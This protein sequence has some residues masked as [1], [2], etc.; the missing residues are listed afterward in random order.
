RDTPSPGDALGGA[1]AAGTLD[2]PRPG[3]GVTGDGSCGRACRI[4]ARR[5]RGDRR[6]LRRA[7]G[8]DRPR[9]PPA[10]AHARRTGD[11]RH[12]APAPGGGDRTVRDGALE[13]GDA[14]SAETADRA[15][16]RRLR[17]TLA[18]IPVVL[19]VTI[20][21]MFYVALRSG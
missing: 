16:R 20:A 1:A 13:A 14:G 12:A 21:A 10:A 7:D 15:A 11:A 5:L 9:L 18:A 17:A 4:R 2:R 6:R 8:D 19:F 3:N